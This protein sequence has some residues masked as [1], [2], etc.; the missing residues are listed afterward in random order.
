[1]DVSHVKRTLTKQQNVRKAAPEPRVRLR[2]RSLATGQQNELPK[3]LY[4]QI[5]VINHTK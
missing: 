5:Q 1:M 4:D 3:T 2:F